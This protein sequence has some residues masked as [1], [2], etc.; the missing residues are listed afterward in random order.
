MNT[1]EELMAGDSL[2]KKSTVDSGKGVS[3]V[4]SSQAK[5]EDDL[6]HAQID[7]KGK[8]AK[9]RG[10]ENPLK[11][12]MATRQRRSKGRSDW[13]VRGAHK[14]HNRQAHKIQNSQKTWKS[15]DEVETIVGSK[16]Q[17]KRAL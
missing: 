6:P 4:N 15:L 1:G 8:G 5:G 13:G 2:E 11:Y 7:G 14:Q 16:Q 12:R 17:S 9:K 3:K 10:I